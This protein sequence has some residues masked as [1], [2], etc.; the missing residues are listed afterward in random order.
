MRATVRDNESDDTVMQYD[1]DDNYDRPAGVGDDNTTRAVA[2]IDRVDPSSMSRRPS[3]G[4][5]TIVDESDDERSIEPQWKQL[6]GVMTDMIGSVKAG[7]R[8]QERA[9]LIRLLQNAHADLV[10]DVMIGRERDQP[11]RRR[12]ESRILLKGDGGEASEVTRQRVV[13]NVAGEAVDRNYDD[14]KGAREAGSKRGWP[15]EAGS[16]DRAATNSTPS[17]GRSGMTM[18][19]VQKDGF[20]YNDM[21]DDGPA[22][23]AD[24]RDAAG[25]AGRAT[26]GGARKAGEGLRDRPDG[27][28][29]SARD[30][31]WG[32]T[33]GTGAPPR[34]GPDPRH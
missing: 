12:P 13:G 34:D 30:T 20:L 24:R 9:E 7:A 23:T 5:H 17:G 2:P 6:F 21:V 11:P 4:E 28:T 8:T 29:T 14:Y 26:G 25:T 33:T 10:E 31:S 32:R 16:R 18:L 1:D 15:G 22:G 19:E 27:S 3:E